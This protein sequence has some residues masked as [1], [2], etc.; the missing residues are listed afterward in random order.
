MS[1]RYAPTRTNRTPWLDDL[2]LIAQQKTVDADGYESTTETQR[3]IRCTFSEGVT[4]SEFYEAMKAGV[5]LSAEAEIWA[6]EYAGEEFC[7][8]DSARYKI[9]RVFA[10]GRGTLSLSLTEVIR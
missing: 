1:T 8:Y 9:V 7:I 3:V 4:R 5:R 6:S 2:T 10:T